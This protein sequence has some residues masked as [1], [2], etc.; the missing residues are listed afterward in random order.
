MTLTISLPP[1]TEAALRQ[2]A[3]DRG[4][5]LETFVREAVEEKLRGAAAAVA[6]PPPE[7]PSTEAWVRQFD[8]WVGH[9]RRWGERNLPPGHVA[10]DSRERIYGGRGE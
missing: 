4:T 5:D 3:A 9:L 7:P 1:E 2:R 8:E 10:D 6:S